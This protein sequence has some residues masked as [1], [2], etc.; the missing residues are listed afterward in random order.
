MEEG[1]RRDRPTDGIRV[2]GA[3]PG[4]SSTKR[5]PAFG[6]RRTR[7]STLRFRWFSEGE[8]VV[9]PYVFGGS[10]RENPSLNRASTRES[11][12]PARESH[13]RI[14]FLHLEEG[15]RRDRPTDRRNKGLGDSWASLELLL[16]DLGCRL[17]RFEKSMVLLRR[18]QG[19]GRGK[20][21]PARRA[22]AR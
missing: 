20:G 5:I 22:G 11:G 16:G 3:G 4:E 7:R 21:S 14:G 12:G 18:T 1:S 19:P 13:P 6:G 2:W 17:A 15:S 9:Q 10:P 8:T